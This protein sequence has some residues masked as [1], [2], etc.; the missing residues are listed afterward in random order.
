MAVSR[1]ELAPKLFHK[2]DLADG[3]NLASEVRSAIANPKQQV[4][5]VVYNAVDDHLSGPDQLNQRWALED[6]RNRGTDQ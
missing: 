5:G 3:G 1:A 2:G 6:R 4:V